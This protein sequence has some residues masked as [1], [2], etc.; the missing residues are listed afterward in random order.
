MLDPGEAAAIHFDLDWEPG[1]LEVVTGVAALHPIASG[2]FIHCEQVALGDADGY[3]GE[4]R[5][6]VNVVS[7]RA[8]VRLAIIGSEGDGLDH[9][10]LLRRFGAPAG[11]PPGGAE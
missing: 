1:G 8:P 3:M 9:D 4:A 11:R 10:G 6:A 2:A 7:N 5:V